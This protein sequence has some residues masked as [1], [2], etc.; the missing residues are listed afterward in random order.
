MC[1]CVGVEGDED[2]RWRGREEKEGVEVSFLNGGQGESDAEEIR[3][4]AMWSGP[5]L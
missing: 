2:E 1:V 3:E 4:S 5:V